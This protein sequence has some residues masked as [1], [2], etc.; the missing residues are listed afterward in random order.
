[1]LKRWE[2]KAKGTLSYGSSWIIKRSTQWGPRT[3][4]MALEAG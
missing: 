2:I 3:G 1:M 4:D